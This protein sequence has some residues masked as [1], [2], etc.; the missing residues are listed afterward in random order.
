MNAGDPEHPAAARRGRL[1]GR[2][3]KVF[4]GNYS[5]RS[6]TFH[7]GYAQRI[8]RDGF[9]EETWFH[10]GAHV[11][12][13]NHQDAAGWHA[14]QEADG[15]YIS[16]YARDWSPY[17]RAVPALSLAATAMLSALLLAIGCRRRWR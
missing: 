17:M 8:L 14:A 2:I 10:E 11:A 3:P 7:T 13:Q 5:D 6:F 1:G 9:L 4:G 12:L 15:E 16:D